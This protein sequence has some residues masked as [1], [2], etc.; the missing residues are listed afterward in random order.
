MTEKKYID[1]VWRGGPVKREPYERGQTDEQPNLIKRPVVNAWF[2][3]KHDAHKGRWGRERRKG[4]GNER[5]R[6]DDASR[7]GPGTEQTGEGFPAMTEAS[8]DARVGKGREREGGK[9]RGGESQPAQES[10][11][12]T[13]A[14]NSG[15]TRRD[16]DKSLLSKARGGRLPARKTRL[17]TARNDK[18]KGHHW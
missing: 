3:V 6:I 8:K 4:R 2:V 11:H 10:S 18:V 14:N 12:P 5:K 1:S 17:K 15:P 16:G 9:K 7:K 13:L